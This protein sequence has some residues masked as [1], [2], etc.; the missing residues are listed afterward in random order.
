MCKHKVGR[1]T[2]NCDECIKNVVYFSNEQIK[3]LIKAGEIIKVDGVSYY[4]GA[5]VFKNEKIK[6]VGL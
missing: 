4:Y 2:V 3:E 1:L 6:W 5:L